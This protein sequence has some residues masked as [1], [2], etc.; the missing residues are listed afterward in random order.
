[1]HTEK[2]I[3]QRLENLESR[4]AFQE[5]TIEILNQSVIEHEKTI[6]RLQTQLRLLNQKL[7]ENQSLV[8]PPSEETPPPHY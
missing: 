3:E 4:L 1:M 8:A 5:S 7:Q 2:G 6:A